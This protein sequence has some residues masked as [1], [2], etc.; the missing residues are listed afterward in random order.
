MNLLLRS[1]LLALPF[2]IMGCTKIDNSTG[3]ASLTIVNGING[4][5]TVLT[6]FQPLGPKGTFESPLQYYSK[7]NRIGYGTSWKSGSYVR[8]VSLSLFAYPDTTTIRWQGGFSLQNGGIYTLF[9]GGDTTSIDTLLSMDQIPYYPVSDSV[10][11]MRVVNL[12]GGSQPVAINLANTTANPDFS[13]LG[14][15]QVSGFKQY[16]ASSTGPGTYSF[17]IRDQTS[18]SVLATFDWS[19]TIFKNNTFVIIGSEKLAGSQPI[20]VVV[21]NNF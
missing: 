4:N 18:D 21:I 11:G 15:R 6:N 12:I 13:N 5:S 17:E 19:Y 9:L 10:S 7:A 2:I 1:W 14:Y 3:S 20:Q 8:Q 16:D